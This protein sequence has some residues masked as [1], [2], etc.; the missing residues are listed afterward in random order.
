[1]VNVRM[2]RERS[3]NRRQYRYDN[4]YKKKYRTIQLSR[5]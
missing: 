3:I 4:D 2:K 5:E 1:M